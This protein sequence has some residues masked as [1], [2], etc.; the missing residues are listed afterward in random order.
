MA[1]L[2]RVMI[3]SEYLTRRFLAAATPLT[4]SSRSPGRT[5]HRVR[6]FRVACA[7]RYTADDA[8]GRPPR[9][10]RRRRSRR[11]PPPNS[12][13]RRRLS[14]SNPRVKRPNRPRAPPRGGAV[15]VRHVTLPLDDVPHLPGRR[16]AARRRRFPRVSST[17]RRA[18]RTRHTR[19]GTRHGTSG[20]RDER[21]AR[22][23]DGSVGRA[24]DVVVGEGEPHL[25]DV[26]E[27]VPSSSPSLREDDGVARSEGV[28]DA[29]GVGDGAAA[30]EDVEPLG[31][32]A[33]VGGVPAAGEHAHEPH[34]TVPSSAP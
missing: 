29:V 9:R 2:T 14:R 13:E 4:A 15:R 12:R 11:R 34:E 22:D 16:R 5:A 25:V 7:G 31:A 18:R 32:R 1:N 21:R 33:R 8:A 26:F 10:A 27:D 19:D 28:L 24:R 17:P 23:D 30:A 6:R 3:P 20:V